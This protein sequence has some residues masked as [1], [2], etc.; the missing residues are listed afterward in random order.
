MRLHLYLLGTLGG[1][2]LIGCASW[3]QPVPL[4][5]DEHPA[6]PAVVA[7][8]AVPSA[9]PIAENPSPTRIV[10]VQHVALAPVESAESAPPQTAPLPADGE[11]SLTLVAESL[12]RG[13]KLAAAKHLEVYVRRHPDQVMFRLQAAE[14]LVQ[15]QRDD[16]AKV[17]FEQFIAAAQVASEPIQQ[18]LVHSHTRLMEIAQ[19]QN[20]QFG[21]LFH[22]GVGLLLLVEEQDKS[23]NRDAAFCEEMLCKALRALNEARDLNP[24]DPRTR[25]YLAEIYTRMGNR[26]GARGERSAAGDGA[27]PGELTRGER[28]RILIHD[29]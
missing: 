1:V 9:S 24:G 21:E 13:D 18:Y 2:G 15:A 22:R 19:R 3:R 7:V 20:D 16:R 23:P 29:P 8:Q 17:H 28:S 12:E 25:V 27:A 14:L 5:H 26:R 10:Q 4:I 6:A 11:D